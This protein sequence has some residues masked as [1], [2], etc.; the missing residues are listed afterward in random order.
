MLPDP[1]SSRGGVV[2]FRY[3]KPRK[4]Y[5]GLFYFP[6]GRKDDWSKFKLSDANGETPRSNYFNLHFKSKDFLDQLG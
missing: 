2:G 5:I 1:N 4:E 3:R 6:I